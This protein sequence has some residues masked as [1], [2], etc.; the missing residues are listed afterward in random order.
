MDLPQMAP[1][2]PEIP[3]LV[4][5]DREDG[6]VP[7]ADGDAIAAAWPGAS[8]EPTEGLG[9][10]RILRAPHVLARAV[11]FVSAHVPATSACGHGSDCGWYRGLDRCDRCGLEAELFRPSARAASAI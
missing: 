6:E 2:L 7:F 3:L 9:H 5:H 10:R 8:I 1:S 4:L 11:E